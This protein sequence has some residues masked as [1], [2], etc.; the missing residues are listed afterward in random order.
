VVR[1]TLTPTPL[2]ST[3]SFSL[4]SSLACIQTGSVWIAASS[5]KGFAGYGVF[6]TRDLAAGDAI[7]GRPDGVAIPVE[8]AYDPAA[9]KAAE[10]N[11]WLHVWYVARS[12]LSL[13]R[14]SLL[15][16]P[17][18]CR[19]ILAGETSKCTVQTPASSPMLRPACSQPTC[20]LYYS[21]WGRGVPDHA[22]YYAG[23]DVVEYQIA[24]GAL[25]NHH[26]LLESLD[27]VYPKPPYDDSM[28]NRFVDAGAGAFTYVRGFD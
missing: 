3:P 9:P 1:T 2:R 27:Y 22:R 5:L 10:R 4:S 14:F 17:P 20:A 12:N 28:V 25:P 6:T 16:H 26:C 15:S 18:S 11:Q 13:C 24:F 21:Y 19:T 8:T 23:T 7:I